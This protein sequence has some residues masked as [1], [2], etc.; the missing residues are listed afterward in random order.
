[1]KSD[2][3]NMKNLRGK[4][5]YSNAK[6]AN[7][8]YEFVMDGAMVYTQGSSDTNLKKEKEILIARGLNSA[9]KK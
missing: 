8:A 6:P 4:Y 3:E 7:D 9:D 1:M 5:V 2:S